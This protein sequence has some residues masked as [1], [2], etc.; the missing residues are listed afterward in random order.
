MTNFG[1]RIRTGGDGGAAANC[2]P[3]TDQPGS[4]ECPRGRVTVSSGVDLPLAGR[5]GYAPPVYRSF[6][7]PSHNDFRAVFVLAWTIGVLLAGK[8]QHVSPRTT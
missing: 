3:H 6:P 4:P 1:K 5:P 8:K 2:R 7:V